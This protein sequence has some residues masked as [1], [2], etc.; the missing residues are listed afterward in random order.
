MVDPDRLRFD[1]SAKRG[2]NVNDISKTEA[3]VNDIVSKNTT[4]Y[5][6]VARYGFM[7]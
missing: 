4:V 2:M 1:Y 7:F 6:K 3:I 5:A